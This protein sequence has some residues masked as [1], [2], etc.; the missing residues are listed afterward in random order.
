MLRS[1]LPCMY[2]HVGFHGT[3]Q[4]IANDFDGTDLEGIEWELS[5]Y[6]EG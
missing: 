6:F 5:L 3:H 4:L 2:P 1:I